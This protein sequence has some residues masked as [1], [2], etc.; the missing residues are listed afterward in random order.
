[1]PAGVDIVWIKVHQSDRDAAEGRARLCDLQG[2]RMAD[3]AA[4][5]WKHWGAV[6]QAVRHFWRTCDL[7]YLSGL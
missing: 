6:C 4:K 2:N 5:E 7:C 3:T 1:M